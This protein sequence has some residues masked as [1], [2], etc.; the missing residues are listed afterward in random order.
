MTPS[1]AT[2]QA[3][4]MLRKIPDANHLLARSLFYL[5]TYQRDQPGHTAHRKLEDEAFDLYKKQV[6]GTVTKSQAELTMVDY[7]N[8]LAHYFR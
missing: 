8:L 4:K 2:D 7:D 6:G 1:L 3:V 5:S